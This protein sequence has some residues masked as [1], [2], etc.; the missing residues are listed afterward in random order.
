MTIAPK[1]R[2]TLGRIMAGLITCLTLTA[3]AL[4]DSFDVPDIVVEQPAGTNIVDG[5]SAAGAAYAKDYRDKRYHGPDD[6]YDPAWNW[7]GA[8]ADLR[9]YYRLGRSL[10][11]SRDWPN[12]L[13]GDEF[14]RA[15]D[16]SRRSG[17]GKR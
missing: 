9:V 5:G 14:R 15:R 12:W 6:E 4:A 2:N 1:T 3:P 10:A 11:D 7:Q 16:E 13:P 8:V 17:A